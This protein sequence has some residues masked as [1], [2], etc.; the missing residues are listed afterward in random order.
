MGPVKKSLS[1]ISYNTKN[2]NSVKKKLN[3]N[4]DESVTN[5]SNI[6]QEIQTADDD[7]PSNFNI[8]EKQLNSEGYSELAKEY[9][10]GYIFN[11][12]NFDT[13]FGPNY[14]PDLNR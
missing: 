11:K 14:D 2:L 13:T 7:E 5:A 9:I 12:R 10:R 3:P 6:T 1:E 4:G 8:I